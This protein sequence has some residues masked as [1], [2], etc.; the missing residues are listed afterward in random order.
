MATEIIRAPSPEEVERKVADW[1]AAHPKTRIVQEVAAFS[2][3][4]ER[5]GWRVCIDYE[6]PGEEA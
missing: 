4:P 5:G 2:R 1:K 3:D 6:E